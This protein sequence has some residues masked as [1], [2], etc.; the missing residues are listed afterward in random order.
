MAT[1]ELSVFL[2][3]NLAPVS[4]PGPAPEKKLH[5]IQEVR[6]L[7][8]MSLRTAARQLDSDVRVVRAQ[9]QAT[10][11]LRLSDVCRWQKILDVPLVDLLEDSGDLLSRPVSERAKMVRVMKTAA[12]ML[13]IAESPAMQRMAENLVEQLVD[14]MPELKEV[15]AWHSVGQRRG[16]GDVGRIGERVYDDR[17]I[18]SGDFD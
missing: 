18:C 2:G 15:G 11:D 9:E 16:V 14:I 17:A 10:T 7:Q 3:A 8:G 1:A 12:A 5:R 13:E 6:R 4:S